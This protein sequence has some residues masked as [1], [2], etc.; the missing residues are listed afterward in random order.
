LA[1]EGDDEEVFVLF[2]GER[3]LYEQCVTESRILDQADHGH[4][5]TEAERLAIWIYTSTDAGWYARI[6]G[7]LWNPP[8]SAEVALFASVL[9]VALGNIPPCDRIV[10]RGYNADDLD[11]F[12]GTYGIGDVIRWPGF[13]SSTLDPAKAFE[14][15]VLFTIRSQKGR[16]LGQYAD[17]PAEEEV[18][19]PTGCRFLIISVERRDDV[20][21][22]EL[23]E[24]P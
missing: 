24:R 20:A 5:L 6:N 8:C 3:M 13:T 21:F 4:G 17:K 22:I 23:E 11:A 1:I 12:L 16:I 14:G 7:E 19:F 18:L 9:N 15:N 2:L 10:Y